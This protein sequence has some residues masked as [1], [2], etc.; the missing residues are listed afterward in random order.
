M[1]ASVSPR[2][3][4]KLFSTFGDCSGVWAAWIAADRYSRSDIVSLARSGMP[5]GVNST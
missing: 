5:S 3:T 1:L 4:V 2:R